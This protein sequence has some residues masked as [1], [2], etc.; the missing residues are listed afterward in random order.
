MKKLLSFK[1]YINYLHIGKSTGYTLL[2]EGK[3]K[4]CRIGKKWLIPEEAIYEYLKKVK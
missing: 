3:V 4:G 1:E 2:K